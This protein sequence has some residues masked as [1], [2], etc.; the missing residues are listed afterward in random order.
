M[1]D[2]RKRRIK[3]KKQLGMMRAALPKI[4]FTRAKCVTRSWQGEHDRDIAR[5]WAKRGGL[6]TRD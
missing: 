2:R 3:S 1:V 6:G 4:Q 5:V